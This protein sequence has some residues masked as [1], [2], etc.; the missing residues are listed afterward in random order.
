MIVVNKHDI[1]YQ[2]EVGFHSPPIFEERHPMNCASSIFVIGFI[3]KTFIVIAVM[4]M[5]EA[6]R[7]DLDADINQYLPTSMSI[8][9]P[10]FPNTTIS[11]RHLLTHSSGIGLDLIEQ[12][13][14]YLPDDTFTQ[15][16]MGDII[17]NYLSKNDS[18][19]PIPPG[20]ITFY[21]NVGAALAA[22]IVERLAGTLF[23]QYAEEKILKV[24]N[25]DTKTAG[26]RLSNFEDVH[27]NLVDHYVYNAS[28]RE[29]FQKYMP[30]L[31]I[32]QVSLLHDMKINM[33][34]L[35]WAG[36]F[37]DWLYFPFF[38]ISLYPAGLLRMS[39]KTLS[40]WLQAFMNNFLTLIR[41]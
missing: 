2:E 40:M 14:F 15:T 25:I 6:N 12:Y 33:T 34:I 39:A 7:L 18:W 8:A 37:S 29:P 24:L 10:Y 30:Q 22:Y 28:W 4:Q 20:N 36:N 21:S 38:G 3:S 17:K 13:K 35:I 31:D 41:N 5:V 16:N 27:E 32:S 23:E 19:L 11:T 1:L 26:Y 9:H